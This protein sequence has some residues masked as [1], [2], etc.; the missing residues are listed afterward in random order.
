M[1]VINIFD[2]KDL[3]N[4]YLLL[5][6]YFL[7]HRKIDVVVGIDPCED[8]CFISRKLKI[9]VINYQHGLIGSPPAQYLS[10]ARL[11]QLKEVNLPTR[12]WVW[13]KCYQNAIQ[14]SYEIS[15]IKSDYRCTVVGNLY[16]NRLKMLSEDDVEIKKKHIGSDEV[17][18]AIKNRSKNRLIVLISLSHHPSISYGHLLD[19]KEC[20]FMSNALVLSIIERR[21]VFWM[22]RMH[23]VQ[24][25]NGEHRNISKYLERLSLCNNLD[26][27][28]FKLCNTIPLALLFNNVAKFHLTHNSNSVY[29]AAMSGVKS[30]YLDYEIDKNINKKGDM[31]ICERS[32][33]M[34]F[35]VDNSRGGI[36]KALNDV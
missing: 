33:G 29:E 13:S 22:I 25:A 20:Q 19:L 36:V 4:K 1:S 18:R 26:N 23:P 34:A 17:I 7:I 32:E 11:T 5:L 6:E 3:R 9:D 16:L 24:K 8:L 21:D 30:G 14:K 10:R 35:S 2:N 15:G 31:F 12:Y 27:I 28:D